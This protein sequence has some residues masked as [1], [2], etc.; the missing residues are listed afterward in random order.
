[1]LGIINRANPMGSQMRELWVAGLVGLLLMASSV[2]PMGMAW[3]HTEAI[4]FEQLVNLNQSQV[5]GTSGTH[6][7]SSDSSA[8][9]EHCL[10][11]FLHLWLP[12]AAITPALLWSGLVWAAVRKYNA[13]IRSSLHL[14]SFAPRAPPTWV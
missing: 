9:L 1:M 12:V 6:P 8:H 13:R 11:C 4:G 5:C 2:A 7:S 3:G 14:N 10:L